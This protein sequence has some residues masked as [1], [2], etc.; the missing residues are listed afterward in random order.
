MDPMIFNILKYFDKLEKTK[1]ILIACGLIAIFGIIDYLTGPELALS[2]FYLLPIMLVAWL[3]DRRAAVYIS[4]LGAIVWLL[5]DVLSK[6]WYVPSSIHW[7][8]Y[9]NAV[10]RLGFFL[11]ITYILSALKQS[12]DRETERARTDY[13]TGVA[14]MRYFYELAD[15]ELSRARRY[16]RPLTI[17]YLDIDNFKSVNDRL[18]HAAGDLLLKKVAETIR[19][20]IRVMDII[21]RVGGDEFVLLFPE[22]GPDIAPSVIERIQK[23]LRDVV[24]ENKWPITFSIGALT[25]ENIFDSVDALVT[26]SDR[27][28]YSVKA[29][30][31]DT[32][33]YEIFGN[34][35][36]PPDFI[37][38]RG[39]K[40]GRL[41]GIYQNRIVQ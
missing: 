17:A 15:T 14:N 25:C 27:L 6:E 29:A 5:A 11:I 26:A 30:G 22:T 10:V 13:L 23:G 28:M 7:I 40:K 41:A 21:A 18:G 33:R 32:V 1:L 37:D 8:P 35:S 9:W 12:T 19:N 38:P 2:I 31:K 3:V 4:V 24:Q 16:E 39:E 20:S 36:V 34:H